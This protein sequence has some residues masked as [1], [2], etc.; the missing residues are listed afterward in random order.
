LF[1]F[2]FS[3]TN[4]HLKTIRLQKPLVCVTSERKNTGTTT[5]AATATSTNETIAATA[6]ADWIS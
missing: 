2:A 1:L 3:N 6:T 4:H 5:A